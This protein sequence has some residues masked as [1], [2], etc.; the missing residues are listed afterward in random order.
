MNFIRK[1]GNKAIYSVS[2]VDALSDEFLAAYQWLEGV[3]IAIFCP[4]KPI[5]GE[6]FSLTRISEK[7]SLW[8]TYSA[9]AAELGIDR[10][11]DQFASGLEVSCLP[12]V[13]AL[14]ELFVWTRKEYYRSINKAMTEWQIQQMNSF[15]KNQLPGSRRICLKKNGEL[16]GL[17]LLTKSK[18]LQDDPVDWVPWVWISRT[19]PAEERLLVHSCF[20]RW[21][22]DQVAEKVQCVVSAYNSRSQKFFRKLG[23]HPECVHLIKP[24]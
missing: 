22:K 18:D 20:K 3:E 16:L 10:G 23:F 6:A 9:K 1:S 14:L 21:L 19:L 5:D 8:I 7:H 11:V 15:I 17:F 24:K 2:S 13:G 12:D 4:E